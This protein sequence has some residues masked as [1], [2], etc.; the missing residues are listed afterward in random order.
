[1]TEADATEPAPQR[2]E[3]ALG[4]ECN[5]TRKPKRNRFLPP[6]DEQLDALEKKY[7]E[8]KHPIRDYLKSARKKLK[9]DQEINPERY[10][11]GPMGI[12]YFEG[13]LKYED[14]LE[15]SAAIEEERKREES[16]RKKEEDDRKHKEFLAKAVYRADGFDL[17][18]TPEPAPVPPPSVK[19][20]PFTDEERHALEVKYPRDKVGGHVLDFQPKVWAEF[21][22]E[23][24]AMRFAEYY[25][26][27]LAG[28]AE[29]HA[30]EKEAVCT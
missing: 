13:Y 14:D 23:K 4:G 5:A 30:Q 7:P 9:L 25:D 6:D 2:L 18:R 20:A 24:P 16:K 19:D 28:E 21:K 11:P 8:L 29:K 26:L 27:K 17:R 22:Q 10:K 3:D 1:M 15:E 12:G